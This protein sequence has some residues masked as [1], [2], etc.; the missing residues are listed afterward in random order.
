MTTI[1]VAGGD[2]INAVLTFAMDAETPILALGGRYADH[3]MAM[4]HQAFGPRVGIPRLLR[5]LAEYG[6]PATFFVPGY[7]ADHWPNAVAAILEANHEVGHHSY[8]HRPPTTLSPRE[9]RYE[10]E[11]GL[12]SLDR[13][14]VRPAGYRAPMWA[15]TWHTAG[16]VREHGMVYDSSLMDD[17]RPYVI[18]T[19]HGEIAEIP[20]HWSLDDWE[21]YAYL[22]E[23]AIGAHI[24]PP[25]KV[26]S[27]WTA[28][29][30][31]MRRH[32]GLFVL[33][34]HAFLSG[35]A[36]RV[37][38]LRRLIEHALDSGAVR[39]GT[40]CDVARQTLAD[41][42]TARRTHRRPAVDPSI[43]PS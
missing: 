8:S 6:L 32:G 41:P 40:A 15:A 33:T 42:T 38:G 28:E 35:R 24:E 17:D 43:Y 19:G 34:C 13:V 3:A 21:Q 25:D 36:S 39:F 23:P 31:G 18:G 5:L 1:E 9:D 29:L 37:E 27:L 4:T 30:D 2:R 22:A 12:E 20:P 26:V 16:L 11:R 7:A 14:G 10:F